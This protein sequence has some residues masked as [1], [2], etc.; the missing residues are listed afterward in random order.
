VPFAMIS[1]MREPAPK[2]FWKRKR[3]I[4]T[5]VL[6]LLLAYPLGFGV[7]SYADGRHWVSPDLYGPLQTLYFPCFTTG[8]NVKPSLA[9]V[10]QYF[11]ELGQRH[12]TTGVS[13][14]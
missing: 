12:R 4:A 6:W 5:A 1:G 14:G 11:Y 10:F 3:W 7:I 8:G 13:S 9:P 2:P